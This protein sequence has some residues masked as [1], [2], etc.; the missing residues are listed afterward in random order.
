MTKRFNYYIYYFAINHANNHANNHTKNQTNDYANYHTNYHTNCHDVTRSKQRKWKSIVTSLI[1]IQMFQNS[2]NNIEFFIK[3]QAFSI[4]KKINLIS[5]K[6]NIDFSDHNKSIELDDL[7]SNNFFFKMF[8]QCRR[9]KQ[10][11]I[12]RNLLHKHLQHCSKDI[13]EFSNANRIEKLDRFWRKLW[14]SEEKM[15][16]VAIVDLITFKYRFTLFRRCY[17]HENAIFFRFFE[18]CCYEIDLLLISV[19]N[20]HD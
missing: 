6:K 18:T 20:H 3:H 10:Q 2:I 12:S 4:H 11:F 15:L 19:I 7:Q 17:D 16:I 9:C 1:N 5:I 8:R 13:K 14:F